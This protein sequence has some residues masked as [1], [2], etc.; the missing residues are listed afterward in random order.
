M[1][2]LLKQEFIDNGLLDVINYIIVPVL[3]TLLTIWSVIHSNNKQIKNQNKQTYKPRLRLSK[4]YQEKVE[5]CHDNYQYFAV[6]KFANKE[7]DDKLKTTIKLSID[8]SN[9]GNGIAHGI[10]FY[11]LVD[12]SKCTRAQSISDDKNQKMAS[13]EEIGNKEDFKF[14]FSVTILNKIKDDYDVDEKHDFLLLLCDYRDFNNNHYKMFIGIIIK[15]IFYDDEGY[16]SANYD[17]YYYH[18]N[19]YEYNTMVKKHLNKYENILKKI[20]KDN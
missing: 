10:K 15:K 3:L 5:N 13:T 2:I 1:N 18:E 9:I 6:S 19:T 17:H 16:I 12:G 11:N 7:K 8:L 20:K 14:Y 4:I